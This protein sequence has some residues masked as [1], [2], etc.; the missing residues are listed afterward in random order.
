[1]LTTLLDIATTAS[2]I[3]LV[4]IFAAVGVAVLPWRTTE[5]SEA[6][7]ALD[8]A[9]RLSIRLLASAPTPAP[10]PARL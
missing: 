9:G 1:M 2:A 7:Q 5:A 6:S 4:S 3:G 10:S 8:A